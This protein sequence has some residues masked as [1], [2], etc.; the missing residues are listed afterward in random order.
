MANQN[1]QP[2]PEVIDREIKVLE[3]RRVGLTWA[4]IADQ[5]GYADPTGAYAAYKRAVKRVLK[6]PVQEVLDQ[7]LD[8]LDRLQV[9]VWGRAMKGDDRAINTILRLMERRAKLLGLDAAQKVQAE[10]TTFDGHRDI[11]GEIE[12]IVE[13][14]RNANHGQPM[15]LEGG[16]SESG[17]ITSEGELVDL[18]LHGGP[19]SGQDENG[20]G[21]DSLGSDPSAEHTLGDSRTDIL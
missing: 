4:N 11:D 1:K 14:I 6:E 5:V 8:R 21:V 2:D 13:I 18:A 17:T 3:L 7:E 20:S 9:A 19:W 15:A 10:V 12:R 16:T